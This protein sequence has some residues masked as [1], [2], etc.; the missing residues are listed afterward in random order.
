MPWRSSGPLEATQRD[1]DGHGGHTDGGQWLLANEHSPIRARSWRGAGGKPGVSFEAFEIST[2]PLDGGAS[3][4]SIVGTATNPVR[5]G[6]VANSETLNMDTIAAEPGNML[7]LAN[8][9]VYSDLFW[10]K[11]ALAVGQGASLVL[12]QDRTGAVTGTVYVGDPAIA[13]YTVI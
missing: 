12:G 9:R 7:Y 5:V 11:E 2:S 8:A 3:N 6:V 4:A 13:G 10:D 1:T